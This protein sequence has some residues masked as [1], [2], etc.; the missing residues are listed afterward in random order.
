MTAAIAPTTP[1]NG[2][3]ATDATA[4]MYPVAEYAAYAD[5]Q[6]LVDRMSDE[7]FP[8]D[9]VRIV[10]SNLTIVEQVT[11]RLTK[12]KAALYGAGSGAWFGLFLGLLFGLFTV[13]GWLSVVLTA[14]VIGAVFGALFGFVAHLAT[15]G[16]RDFS[17]VKGMQAGSYVVETEAGVLNEA[18]LIAQRL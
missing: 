3:I 6:R 15:G 11:G 12:G 8:V 16:R 18:K 10:G 5:A 17:S 7:G 13:G 4:G 2:P 1:S 9:R 14:V